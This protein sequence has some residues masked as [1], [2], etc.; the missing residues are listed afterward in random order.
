MKNFGE[1]V[2]VLKKYNKEPFH[3]E[4]GVTVGLVLGYF[5]KEAGLSDEE[6][7]KGIEEQA[8]KYGMKKEDFE[9]EIGSKEMFKYDLL[10]KKAMKVVQE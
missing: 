2:E 7:E 10:M 4:H 8:E 3:I 9:K 6:V 5:A 1:S